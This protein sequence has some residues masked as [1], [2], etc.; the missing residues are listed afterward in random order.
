M[1]VWPLPRLVALSSSV[2]R[3][4]RLHRLKRCVGGS[5]YNILILF[6]CI[7]YWSFIRQSTWN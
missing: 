7:K 3:V 4:S 1:A 6:V 2:S 5:V